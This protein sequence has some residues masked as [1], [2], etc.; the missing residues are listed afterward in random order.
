MNSQGRI[1]LANL[2]SEEI[3]GYARAELLGQ[4]VEMLIPERFRSL[5]PGHRAGYAATRRIRPMGAGLDMYGLRAELE[6]L[7]VKYVDREEHTDD[8]RDGV[9]PE[10]ALHG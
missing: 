10:G 6:R 8:D 5:H 9:V 2:Q 3:F 4:P 7:G 1:D